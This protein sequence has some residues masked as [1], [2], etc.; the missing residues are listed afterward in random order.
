MDY[1]WLWP[2]YKWSIYQNI[3]IYVICRYLLKS[4]DFSHSFYHGVLGF[5]P[6]PNQGFVS[7][8]CFECSAPVDGSEIL[9]RVVS[10]ISEPSTVCFMFFGLISV[11][12]STLTQ[13]LIWLRDSAMQAISSI[14]GKMVVPLGWC[15]SCL[16]NPPSPLTGDIHGYPNKYPLYKVYIR[17]LLLRGP[18]PRV[19]QHFPYEIRNGKGIEWTFTT[20]FAFHDLRIC[21]L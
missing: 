7:I 4:S 3:Y 19:S 11:A 9:H 12:L 1:Q 20:G 8:C 15:P 6:D 18:F 21:W 17:G 2:L 16:Y 10:Q 13:G 5:H 14:I